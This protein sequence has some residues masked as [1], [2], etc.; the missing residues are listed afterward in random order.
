MGTVH[1]G[2][3]R[4]SSNVFR[5]ALANAEAAQGGKV[6]PAAL[7]SEA[8][9]QDKGDRYLNQR[10]FAAAVQALPARPP[11]PFGRPYEALLEMSKAEFAAEAAKERTYP[12]HLSALRK[13]SVAPE[14][15][16]T[17]WTAAAVERDARADRIA[18][19]VVAGLTQLGWKAKVEGASAAPDLAGGV[20][21]DKYGKSSLTVGEAYSVLR[22]SAPGLSPTTMALTFSRFASSLYTDERPR[23]LAAFVDPQTLELY[24]S[25][26][27][28][29]A[30][31]LQGPADPAAEAQVAEG[32][33]EQLEGYRRL[34]AKRRR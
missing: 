22:L 25:G 6:A 8:K 21:P 31:V 2:G 13:P 12:G 3:Y 26:Y 20:L 23:G 4:Y 30:R 10:E 32:L 29:S 19:L 9:R 1:A 17:G 5:R 15:K 16:G 14:A 18:E 27:G 11:A 7:L 34:N 33:I 24:G 28:F